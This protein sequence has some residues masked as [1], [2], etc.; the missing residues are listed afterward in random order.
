VDVTYSELIADPMAV[1]QRIYN[2]LEM[3]LSETAA[4]RMRRLAL[5]RSRYPRRNGRSKS[6]DSI[7]NCT[8]DASRFEPYCSRFGVQFK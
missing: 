7:L 3:S 5:N 1:I 2:R 6:T 8:I 4:N